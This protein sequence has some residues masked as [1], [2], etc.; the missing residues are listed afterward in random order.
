MS[1]A[2]FSILVNGL[3]ATVKVP[4]EQGSNIPIFVCASDGD[5]QYFV[6]KSMG[7][8]LHFRLQGGRKGRRTQDF[9]PPIRR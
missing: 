1:T 3:P 9:L 8:T 2:R 7:R 6:K 4:K 5:S